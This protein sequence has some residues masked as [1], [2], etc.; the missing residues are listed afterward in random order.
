MYFIFSSF[1]I[2]IS[3]FFVRN[4]KIWLRRDDNY[5]LPCLKHKYLKV[6]ATLCITCA[7]RFTFVVETL[8]IV[9]DRRQCA[10]DLKIAWTNGIRVMTVS[11][12]N[13]NFIR[14]MMSTSSRVRQRDLLV[15][16]LQI[17]I[18]IIFLNNIVYQITSVET[19][20]KDKNI[21]IIIFIIFFFVIQKS[22][23]K[24]SCF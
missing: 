18:F 9:C 15:C 7:R 24:V 14:S 17:F 21:F 8:G 3:L 2:I 1:W 10:T 6:T 16:F 13:G 4:M 22:E 23:Y 11:I 19:E 12:W 5:F 20:K